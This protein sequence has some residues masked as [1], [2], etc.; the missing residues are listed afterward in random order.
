LP[1]MMFVQYC[2]FAALPQRQA[3]L[4]VLK[5]GNVF[6][7]E[8]VLSVRKLVSDEHEEKNNCGAFAFGQPCNSGL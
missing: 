4:D 1:P 6:N 8:L 7:K 3:M 2:S 5:T